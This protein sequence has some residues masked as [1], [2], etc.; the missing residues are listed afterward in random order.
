LDVRRVNIPEIVPQPASVSA[1]L[2]KSTY[3]L[4]LTYTLATR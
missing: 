1:V 4:Q 3:F 2:K